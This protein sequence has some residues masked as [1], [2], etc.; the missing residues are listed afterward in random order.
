MKIYRNYQVIGNQFEQHIQNSLLDDIDTL[1]ETITLCISK[2]AIPDSINS[3]ENHQYS[4]LLKKFTTDEL[5]LFQKKDF[6]F[7]KR[8]LRYRG[9]SNQASIDEMKMKSSESKSRYATLYSL[10]VT[11]ILEGSSHC[12]LQLY[13]RKSKKNRRSKKKSNKK[14]RK[15]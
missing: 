15:L 10:R 5:K 11:T 13:S 8:F 3:D 6:N 12:N 4:F 7:L 1:F 14:R 2:C 9:K